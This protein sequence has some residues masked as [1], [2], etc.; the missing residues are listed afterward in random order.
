MKI[1]FKA[2][3]SIFLGILILITGSG[4]S[5]AKMVCLKSGYTSITLTTPDDCCG[6]SEHPE[7]SVIEEK[8]CDISNVNVDVL[9]YLVA[10]TQTLEKSIGWFVLPSRLVADF[11]SFEQ[12][13]TTTFRRN[14]FPP[15]IF[16]PPM[17]ILT[18]TFLI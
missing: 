3:V 15:T 5:L 1:W 10:S 16:A 8:C 13:I 12:L 6:E 18:K 11:G 9:H 7:D 4:I 14:I 2:S 17:R